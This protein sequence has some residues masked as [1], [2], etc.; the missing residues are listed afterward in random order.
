MSDVLFHTPR[1]PRHRRTTRWNQQRNDQPRGPSAESATT[2]PSPPRGFASTRKSKNDSIK[3]PTIAVGAGFKPAPFPTPLN[4]DKKRQNRTKTPSRRLSGLVRHLGVSIGN[5]CYDDSRR[6][7]GTPCPAPATPARGGARR[8]HVPMTVR[9]HPHARG[10]LPER[11]VTEEEVIGT[12]EL[13]T[14]SPARFGRTRFR[15]DFAYNAEWRG[16]RYATK[17]VDAFA[18]QE[19]D[20]WLVITVIAHYF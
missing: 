16:R 3:H 15:R 4:E 20:G 12:V 18:V 19:P 9:L 13:G 5:R 14:R 6:V 11:G 8:A 1:H 7:A 10:R 2:A 17:R